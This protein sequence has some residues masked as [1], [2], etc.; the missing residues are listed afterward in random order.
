MEG[1]T[2]ATVN[3]LFTGVKVGRYPIYPKEAI[4]TLGS[5][6]PAFSTGLPKRDDSVHVNFPVPLVCAIMTS[7]Q[8][9]PAYEML[10]SN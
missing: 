9:A 10:K 4:L 1:V 3:E 7:V 8:L 5:A 6:G 2:V